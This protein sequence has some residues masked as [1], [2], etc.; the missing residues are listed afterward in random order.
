MTTRTEFKPGDRIRRIRYPISL[1][2][3]LGF[4]TE[5]VKVEGGGVWYRDK[6]GQVFTSTPEYFELIHP[7]TFEVKTVVAFQGE[8][9]RDM[10][11]ERLLEVIEVL[12]REAYPDIFKEAA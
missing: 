5:V 6:Y 9:I 2:A 12:G 10:T 8:P 11:R 4:E 7:A 3:P 1:V